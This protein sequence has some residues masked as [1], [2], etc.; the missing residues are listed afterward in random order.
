MKKK[1]I[2][3]NFHRVSVFL[4][5]TTKLQLKFFYWITWRKSIGWTNK[6]FCRV[7]QPRVLDSRKN[8]TRAD[9]LPHRRRSYW[10]RGKRFNG[11]RSRYPPLGWAT[12]ASI[13]IF[14][15]LFWKRRFREA[16]TG[17]FYHSGNLNYKILCFK[18]NLRV[19]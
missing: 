8:N 19:L 4:Q 13:Y 10:R 9:E 6:T 5:I 16:N 2:K 17:G 7:D 15:F 1:I 12:G 18:F 14:F 3:K 11:G